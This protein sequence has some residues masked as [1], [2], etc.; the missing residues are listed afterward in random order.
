MARFLRRSRRRYGLSYGGARRRSMG[1][2]YRSNRA[3]VI[4]RVNRAEVKQTQQTHSFPTLSASAWTLTQMALPAQ[5]VTSLLREGTVIKA[6]NTVLRFQGSSTNVIP[7]V[8]FRV[9]IFLW[10]QG[11]VS[12]SPGDVVDSSLVNPISAPYNQ[13]NARNY[14]ILHDKVY[15]RHAVATGNAATFQ[16]GIIHG[17]VARRLNQ[18]IT[19]NGTADND[20]DVMPYIMMCTD[21]LG[22][23]F[24]S[25]SANST[26]KFIDL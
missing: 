20:G 3:T 9:V 7:V 15:S 17:R 2:T 21:S 19:F 14:V 16:S 13:L 12:P 11:Y 18:I 5:G 4:Q 8:S 23:G 25:V 24:V 6:L 10:K 22:A 26:T 1:R